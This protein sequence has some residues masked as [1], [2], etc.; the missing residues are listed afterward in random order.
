MLSGWGGYILTQ[1]GLRECVLQPRRVHR[2]LCQTRRQSLRSSQG[3]CG[4]QTRPISS[5]A[6]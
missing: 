2:F 4:Q 6:R 1:A 3:I 5:S